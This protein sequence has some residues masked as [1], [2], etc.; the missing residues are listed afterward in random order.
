MLA[1]RAPT[2][3]L[4]QEQRAAGHPLINR[5]SLSCADGCLARSAR[6]VLCVGGPVAVACLLAGTP[7]DAGVAAWTS[8]HHFDVS[9]LA[10]GVLEP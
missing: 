8:E 3:G 7:H 5:G 9:R 4:A 6:G 10:P 1:T 2:S